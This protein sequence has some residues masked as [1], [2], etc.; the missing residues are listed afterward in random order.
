MPLDQSAAEVEIRFHRV[1]FPEGAFTADT[2]HGRAVPP[3]PWHVQGMIPAGQVTLLSGDGG[4]GKSTLALQLCCATAL[5]CAW[6]G[7][8]PLQGRSLYVSAED[9][10]AEIHRRLDALSIFYGR[11]LDNLGQVLVWPLAEKEDAAIVVADGPDMIKTTP[12]WDELAAVVRAWRPALVVIDSV[13]DVFAANEIN[14]GQVRKFVSVNRTLAIE[15]GSAIVM[16]SHPS[17]TGMTSG[18]GLSGSTAWNNSVRSRLYFTRPKIDSDCTP[19]P[20][21]RVLSVLKANYAEAGGEMKLRLRAG[22]FANEEGN[23]PGALDLAVARDRVDGQFLDLLNSFN[24]QKRPVSDRPGANYAP[25]CFAKDPAAAGT[26]KAAFQAAMNRLLPL[27]RIEVAVTGPP[28]RERRQL[29][30]G[31]PA[32]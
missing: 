15:T 6:I 27:R 28:S 14:R 25:A 26:T 12:R 23:G 22:G 13:A 21:A 7:Q 16:L 8:F 24:A 2:L 1:G 3:R 31:R 11:P 18:S 30:P 4:V 17:L 20:S 9:D 32:Q 19:D 10:T 5:G 29:I